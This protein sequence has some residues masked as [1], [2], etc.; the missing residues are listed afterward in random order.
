MFF[1]FVFTF[2]FFYYSQDKLSILVIPWFIDQLIR[3]FVA[4][5]HY[6]SQK[7]LCKP[8]FLIHNG[9][10]TFKYVVQRVYFLCGDVENIMNCIHLQ[11]VTISGREMVNTHYVLNAFQL[12]F[13]VRINHFKFSNECINNGFTERSFLLI[14]CKS[15]LAVCLDLSTHPPH[16]PQCNM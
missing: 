9:V 3:P 13:A 6:S 14:A 16:V 5:L 7:C 2:L 12:K 10:P 15:C 8:D 4:E 1:F 11:C